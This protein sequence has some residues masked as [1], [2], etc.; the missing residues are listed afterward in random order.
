VLRDTAISLGVF[1]AVTLIALAAG[2]AN[3]G[4]ALGLG[5]IAFIAAGAILLGYVP[6]SERTESESQTEG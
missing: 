3:L 5:Q 6:R 4:T 1:V 2:A